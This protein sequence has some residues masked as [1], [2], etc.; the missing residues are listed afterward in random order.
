ER[1]VERPFDAA[2]ARFW[3]IRRRFSGR[4]DDVDEAR[5]DQHLGDVDLDPAG[6]DDR[7]VRRVDAQLDLEAIDSDDAEVDLH[8]QI[9]IHGQRV[10]LG[11]ARPED[12][13][14]VVDRARHREEP[15]IAEIQLEALRGV[16][17]RL[18]AAAGE[19]EVEPDG[20]VANL[21]RLSGVNV[22]RVDGDA[23]L[24]AV[25][26]QHARI[27]ELRRIVGRNELPEAQLT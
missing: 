22:E 16:E 3:I 1:D 21:E 6:D 24:D 23:E 13:Q 25:V 8:P 26:E 12:L 20:P 4:L 2:E 7:D 10:D 17:D 5:A 27:G 9:E 15:R 11:D 19:V 18:V 14:H